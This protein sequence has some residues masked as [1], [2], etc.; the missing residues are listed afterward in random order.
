MFNC[1]VLP[2]IRSWMK[3]K[4]FL[5]VPTI[6]HLDSK[7]KQPSDILCCPRYRLTNKAS[8]ITTNRKLFVN[9]FYVVWVII[10]KDIQ[11]ENWFGHI[12]RFT[13]SSEQLFDAILANQ[14][15]V[16]HQ[17]LPPLSDASQRY[18]LRPRAHNA[19]LPDYSSHLCQ[20]N[21]INRLLY[22]NSYWKC[23]I[24]LCCV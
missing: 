22:K 10:M 21:F 9:R 14:N 7:L 17:L 1:C 23:F 19:Q 20:S 11:L 5:R 8:F 4:Y 18:I 2:D 16:L 13:C 6:L 24:A 3:V 12:S 15:H